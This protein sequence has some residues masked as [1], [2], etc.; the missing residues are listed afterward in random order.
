MNIQ[1]SKKLR[2]SILLSFLIFGALILS[3][4]VD[5]IA[6]INAHQVERF[7]KSWLKK[8]DF[9]SVGD[10]N[11]AEKNLRVALSLNSSNPDF[12]Q[13]FGRLG[14]WSEHVKCSYDGSEDAISSN[15]LRS[16]IGCNQGRLNITQEYNQFFFES[17]RF[18]PYW[19]YSYADQVLFSAKHFKASEQARKTFY[20]SWDNAVKF[21]FQEPKVTLTLLAASFELWDELRLKYRMSA[22]RLLRNSLKRN[23]SLAYQ[24]LDLAIKSGKLSSICLVAQTE[25]EIPDFILNKCSKLI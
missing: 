21:G 2:I 19:P 18:R 3:S 25:N 24:S 10:F 13:L 5:L 8:K 17:Q 15:L 1:L 14:I 22:L 7:E 4:F 12:L 11:Q 16:D 6:D 9:I 23:R 20:V